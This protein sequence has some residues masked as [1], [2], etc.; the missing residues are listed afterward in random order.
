MWIRSHDGG[1]AINLNNIIS[2]TAEDDGF[3]T[4]MDVN[5]RHSIDQYESYERAVEVISQMLHDNA[6]F[7]VGSSVI[8]LPEE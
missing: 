2:L 6:R 7:T 4:Y 5:G 3:I 8:T 1:I